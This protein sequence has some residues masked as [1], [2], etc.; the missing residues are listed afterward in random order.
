MSAVDLERRILAGLADAQE[1]YEEFVSIEGWM[2]RG[3]DSFA[4]WWSTTVVPTMRALSMRPTREIAAKV[5]ERVREEEQ[6]LPPA[7]RR[8]NAELGA[9]AGVEETTVRRITGSRSAPAADA[10][11]PDLEDQI[12]ERIAERQAETETYA[13]L[14][15]QLDEAME[16]TATRF[17]RNWSAA[18]RAA[19]S[20]WSFDANRVAEVYATDFDREIDRAFL[21]EME[22]FIDAI[23]EAHRRQTSG[24]RVIEGGRA[25]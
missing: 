3:F 5:I 23:R 9:L 24:L 22:R 20:I 15:A 8:T 13:A 19:S 7:Q 4:D 14:D 18:A 11:T 21:A 6:A 1:A 10:A 12:E 17:R 2:E 25:S 16:G